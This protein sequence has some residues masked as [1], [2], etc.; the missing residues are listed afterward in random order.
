MSKYPKK[1]NKKGTRVS[2]FKNELTFQKSQIQ[3]QV[4]VTLM[5][6]LLVC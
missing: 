1:T 2:E 4:E 5:K 6:I 3:E